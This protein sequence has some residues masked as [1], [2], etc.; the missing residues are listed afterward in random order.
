MVHQLHSQARPHLQHPQSLRPLFRFPRRE[1][2]SECLNSWNGGREGEEGEGE[3]DQQENCPEGALGRHP[4][5]DSPQPQPAPEACQSLVARS[6]CGPID[7]VSTHLLVKLGVNIPNHVSLVFH[8]PQ[9]LTLCGLFC[10]RWRFQ[11]GTALLIFFSSQNLLQEFFQTSPHRIGWRRPLRR[12]SSRTNDE[13][14]LGT[15]ITVFWAPT[16]KATFFG[17][18]HVLWWLSEPLSTT[19]GTPTTADGVLVTDPNVRHGVMQSHTLP[20]DCGPQFRLSISHISVEPVT[21]CTFVFPSTP[22]TK[23]V[24]STRE[25][26]SGRSPAVR[27]RL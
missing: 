19:S 16:P 5:R 20:V 12:P 18:P 8:L 3:G 14:V 21:L 6:G 7:P 4:D 25:Y 15:R 24:L 10:L 23:T 9:D 27:H 17:W 22:I 11:S 2:Q 13:V 26:K 1:L